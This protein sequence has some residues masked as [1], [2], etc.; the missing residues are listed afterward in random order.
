MIHLSYHN[1]MINFSLPEFTSFRRMVRSVLTDECLVPFPDGS[2]RIILRTP[3]EGMCFTFLPHEAAE[4][5]TLLDEAF[6]M[7]EIHNLI[8]HTR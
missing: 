7:R 5:T 8:H 2:E 6:Y 1:L 3:F 4:L